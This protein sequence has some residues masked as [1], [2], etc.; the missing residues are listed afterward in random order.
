VP[1][2]CP[3]V[4][5]FFAAFGFVVSAAQQ[6]DRAEQKQRTND[7]LP[8]AVQEKRRRHRWNYAIADGR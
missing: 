6:Q 4:E 8:G 2:T 1:T 7:C 5:S 3:T